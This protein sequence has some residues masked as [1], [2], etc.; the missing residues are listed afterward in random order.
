MNLRPKTGIPKLILLIL[1]VLRLCPLV[2]VPTAEA[3]YQFDFIPSIHI[4]EAYDDNIQ[5]ESTDEIS[6]YI[7]TVSPSIRLDI[8]SE[9]N[10]LSLR[11]APSFVWYR[12]ETQLNTTRHFG[13]ITFMQNLSEHVRFDLKDTI[14]RSDDPLEDFGD[15][16]GER[17][18]RNKYWRN[19]GQ[20]S[21]TYL[22]GREDTF[23]VGYRNNYQA[24]DDPTLFDGTVQTP[25]TNLNYWLNNENG[26]AFD[27]EYTDSNLS[28]EVEVRK[29]S[30]HRIG[31][32]YT[33]RFN[34][35][36]S[37]YFDYHFAL[38]DFD[39]F[40]EDYNVHEISVGH[41]HAL[42][43]DFSYGLSIGYFLQDNE[44]SDDNS[45][46]V[47]SVSLNKRFEHGSFTFGGNGNWGEQYLDP[48]R[49]EFVRFYA[50][51]ANFEYQILRE[52]S[53]YLAGNYRWNEDQNDRNWKTWRANVGLKWTFLRWFAMALDYSYAERMDDI[54]T[55]DFTNN[56]IMLTFSASKL[57][58][59]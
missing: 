56:R 49:T 57:Y 29:F 42:A 36:A 28:S 30:G 21:I 37:G 58:K 43:P 20:A 3:K 6:D 50:A 7:S 24:N 19:T 14:L 32:R 2:T 4:I 59:W 23:S 31:A 54:A 44:I 51:F 48:T 41:D 12:E 1:L 8:L 13:D 47:Y 46:V 34:P 38:R 22:F 55:D 16:P 40:R 52:L 33:H 25:Y 45:G 53:C 18:T 17:T 11:Y 35:R 9:Q 26:L 5:L 15:E 39:V 10:N 27:Y